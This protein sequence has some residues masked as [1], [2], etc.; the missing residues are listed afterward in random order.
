MLFR[1]GG[2]QRLPRAAGVRAALDLITSGRHASAE[3]AL[4]LGIVDRL[5][6]AADLEK[7]A[8]EAA[9]QL[10]APGT[11]LRRLSRLS[12]AEASTS[13]AEIDAFEARQGGHNARLHA[14]Q[15]AIRAV[16]ASVTLPFAEGIAAERAEFV[17]LLADPQSR[18]LRHLFFAE[19]AVTKS[20]WIRADAR[21]APVGKIGRAHV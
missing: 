20:R 8:L 14:P 5:V 7:A 6:P 15:A 1:S 3:E 12:V 19:R 18:A 4:R 9:T 16:R 11:A 17:A 13:L 21:P 2:T 10:A